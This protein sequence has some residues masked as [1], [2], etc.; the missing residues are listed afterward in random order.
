MLDSMNRRESH[1]RGPDRREFV[2]I[3]AGAILAT[4]LGA[5]A[6]LQTVPVQSRS[7]VIRLV[8]HDY[9]QLERAGGFLRIQPPALEHH[10]VVLSQEGGGYAVV[11]PVCTHRGCTVDVAGDRLACPCHGSEYDRSG[12]VVRGPAERSLE[13]YPAELTPEGE[14]VIRLEAR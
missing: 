10:L 1:C 9:P 11:S 3:T 4:G 8:V 6:S 12:Q 14:L 13:R 7:G 5:C 2:Q